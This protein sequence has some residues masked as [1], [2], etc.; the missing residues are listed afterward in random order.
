MG[1]H[2]F[3]SIYV[4]ISALASFFVESTK[5][6]TCSAITAIVPSIFFLQAAGRQVT[7]TVQFSLALSRRAFSQYHS[8][9]IRGSTN[10]V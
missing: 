6:Q 5:S 7:E 3:P 8:L 10:F 9:K 4:S 1:R 2:T